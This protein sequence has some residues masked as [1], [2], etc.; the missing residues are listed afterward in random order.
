M[1][2]AGVDAGGMSWP[3]TSDLGPA[4]AVRRHSE[5]CGTMAVMPDEL[6]RDA[7]QPQ[8][9]TRFLVSRP[10]AEAVALEL[11]E[12]RDLGGPPESGRSFAVLFRGPGDAPLAQGTYEVGHGAMGTFALF[13]VP[14]G[15]D[16]SGAQYEAVFN[17]LPQP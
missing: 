9:G 3:V 6:T 12:I 2:V 14:V 1:V 5:G 10:P 11:V 15:V 4:A 17:R 8:V 13:V 7:F 16:E